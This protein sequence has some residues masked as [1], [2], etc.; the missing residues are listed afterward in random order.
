MEVSGHWQ[1]KEGQVL[2]LEK[3]K[4]PG[5]QND[6][7]LINYSVWLCV[8]IMIR[9]IKIIIII[10]NIILFW[11]FFFLNL[12]SLLLLLLSFGSVDLSWCG[13]VTFR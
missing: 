11:I 2:P 5:E 10:V 12:G 13:D 7:I 8:I 3:S 1:V 4:R 6:R 9:S